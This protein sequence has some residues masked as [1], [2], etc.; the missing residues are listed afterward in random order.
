MDVCQQ[1]FFPFS[2]DGSLIP[3]IQ[4]QLDDVELIQ[5]LVIFGHLTDFHL[6][7]NL[8]GVAAFRIIGGNQVAHHAFSETAWTGYAATIATG[9]TKLLYFCILS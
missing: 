2:L 8:T 3:P 6:A 4:I 7:E 1:K 9:S 5:V